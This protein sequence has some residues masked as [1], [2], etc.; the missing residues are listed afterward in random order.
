MNKITFPLKRRMQGPPV[1]DLQDALQVCLDRRVLLHNDEG[2]RREL[3]AALSR[4]RPEQTYGDATAKAVSV[5]QRERRL[6]PTGEVDQPTAN[7]INALLRE[8]GLL[9]QPPEPI[10]K[11][12]RV[13]GQVVSLVS[14]GVGG[15][16]VVIVDK[17]VGSDVPLA[18]ATT[19]PEPA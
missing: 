18:E 15:L 3:A 19:D 10:P 2:A 11:S 1:A 9:D 6:Q 7:A 17:G 12:Y 8:W 13:E 5:F 4:E 16:R 14:A